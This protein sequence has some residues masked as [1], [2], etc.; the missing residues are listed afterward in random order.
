[1]RQK[2]QGD[3]VRD[4]QGFQSKI[5]VRK[6]VLPGIEQLHTKPI[7]E[8]AECLTTV[9]KMEQGVTQLTWK[10]GE[11]IELTVDR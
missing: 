9:L 5:G 4:D 6:I 7:A 11:C 1:M 3:I 10:I 8:I 2:T